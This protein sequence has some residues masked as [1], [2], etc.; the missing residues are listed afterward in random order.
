MGCSPPD[1]SLHAIFQARILEWVATPS[2]RGSSWPWDQT[3]ISCI[4]GGFLTTEPPREAEEGVKVKSLSH[5]RL[6]A[7][8]WTAAYQAPPSMGFSRQE[9]WIGVPLPSP[10]EGVEELICRSS[11][12]ENVVSVRC[13]IFS[14]QSRCMRNTWHKTFHCDEAAFFQAGWCRPL[15]GKAKS[16]SSASY[17]RVVEKGREMKPREVLRQ[18]L[19][20]RRSKKRDHIPVQKGKDQTE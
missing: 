4:A 20:H 17:S 19:G 2:S 18:I 14:K 10:E 15:S 6:L 9:Y 3:C 16:C 12:S 13:L 5:G 11:L 8:P 7:T 1:S